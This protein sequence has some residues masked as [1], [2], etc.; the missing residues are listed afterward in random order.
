LNIIHSEKVTDAF[1][2]DTRLVV[3]LLAIIVGHDRYA[4]G[5]VLS[6]CTPPWLL[7][8]WLIDAVLPEEDER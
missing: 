1:Y 8:A 6:D 5:T 3:T 4:D 2:M 7:T